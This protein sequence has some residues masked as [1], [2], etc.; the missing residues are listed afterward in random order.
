MKTNDIEKYLDSIGAKSSTERLAAIAQLNLCERSEA[1]ARV[2]KKRQRRI[3]LMSKGLTLNE[4]S[5]I[6][7]AE[8]DIENNEENNI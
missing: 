1:A 5:I 6:V 2:V 3:E 7:N 4:A 8:N